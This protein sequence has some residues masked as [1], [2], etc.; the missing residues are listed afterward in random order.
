MIKQLIAFMIMSLFSGI[1]NSG[2]NKEPLD[3][4]SVVSEK[5]DYSEYDDKNI[6]MAGFV[7][8]KDAHWP[9]VAIDGAIVIVFYQ[10]RILFETVSN[11][12]GWFKSKDALRNCINKE[13][14]ILV[15]ARGYKSY[16]WSDLTLKP[17]GMS[18][19]GEN[20]VLYNEDYQKNEIPNN[21]VILELE[22]VGEKEFVSGLSAN[23][24]N[25][26]Y[27]YVH[28]QNGVPVSL[29]VVTLIKRIVSDFDLSVDA[30][31]CEKDNLVSGEGVCETKE[32]TIGNH[33]VLGK[34]ISGN[35]G[36]FNFRYKGDIPDHLILKFDHDQLNSSVKRY[37][38]LD[39]NNFVTIGSRKTRANHLYS[40]G[41]Q[42]AWH[43]HINPDYFYVRSPVYTIDFVFSYS[44]FPGRGLLVKND[45]IHHGEHNGNSL[46]Q[47]HGL[48]FSFIYSYRDIFVG[49]Q[50]SANTRKKDFYG[51]GVGGIYV[52][53][54]SNFLFRYGLSYSDYSDLGAY[55]GVSIPIA[56]H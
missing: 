39:E 20:N 22:R 26:I 33:V 42:E 27:G 4:C 11:E 24:V 53:N 38:S 2:E 56:V 13:L 17:A 28:D 21:L 10:N 3:E 51:L 55:V 19:H 48:D 36:Y 12:D 45:L 23:R 43:D 40:V 15:F 5:S 52:I 25:N 47:K 35:S 31:S 16:T 29:S 30:S 8:E 32:S 49:N 41:F 7:R 34:A 46:S 6:Y 14:S 44:F 50:P 18:A 1:V 37:I 54:N 9:K